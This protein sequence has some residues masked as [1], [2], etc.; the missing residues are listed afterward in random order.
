KAEV[1]QAEEGFK[2]AGANCQTAEALVHEAE[3]AR[4]R[5]E[6]NCAR[7]QSEY[8]RV[9]TLVRDKVIDEQ[10]QDEALNQCKAAEAAKQEVE[11]KIQSVLAAR[12]ESAARRNKRRADVAP[13]K[14]RLQVAEADHRRMAAWLDYRFVRAPY[15]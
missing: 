12:N 13:A 8:K 7:W 15:D 4:L 6:A 10:S 14:A 3:A 1:D 2:E 11:A 5:V 9:Q